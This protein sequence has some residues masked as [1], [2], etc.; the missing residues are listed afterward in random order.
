MIN[1]DAAFQAGLGEDW[2][3]A[4]A[5]LEH[6]NKKQLQRVKVNGEHRLSIQ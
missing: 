3:A 6:F 2:K 4:R 1:I 5:A